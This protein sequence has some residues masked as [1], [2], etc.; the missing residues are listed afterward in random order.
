MTWFLDLYNLL[1]GIWIEYDSGCK[2]AM[3][4]E[5]GNFI[6]ISFP[7]IWS[8]FAALLALE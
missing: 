4:L 8:I 2:G 7:C 3:S 1:F 5:C 6:Y